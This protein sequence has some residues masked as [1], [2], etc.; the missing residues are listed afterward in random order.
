MTYCEICGTPTPFDAT[1][2]CHNCWE[3]EHRLEAYLKNPLGLDN[4]R[5]LIPKLDDWVEDWH[6]TALRDNGVTVEWDDK[7]WDDEGCP[8]EAP[9]DLVGWSFGWKHGAIFIGRTTETIARKA[10]ALFVELWLRG[11][12]ASFCDKLMD[13]F[14]TY[15]ERQENKSLTFLAEVESDCFFLTR[16][17]FCD[18]EMFGCR[19]EEKIIKALGPVAKDE[20]IIVTFTKRPK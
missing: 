19:L 4:V 7:V 6:E 20:E 2:R 11:V 15:L 17:G 14:I 10:A 5:R 9:P 13:G 1:K 16:N 12:S 18:G 8:Q 3:V